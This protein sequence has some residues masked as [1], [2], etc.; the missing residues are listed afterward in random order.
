[1]NSLTDFNETL[2]EI[3]AEMTTTTTKPPQN[4]TPP[5]TTPNKPLPPV[6]TSSLSP[7]RKHKT[8]EAPQKG[9]DDSVNN[10]L[11]EA[12][13]QEDIQG[14]S[15]DEEE[16]TMSQNIV[17]PA[18]VSPGILR[19]DDSGSKVGGA[20]KRTV[21]FQDDQRQRVDPSYE[22]RIDKET[23][24]PLSVAEAKLKLFGQQE[25]KVA[26]YRR[27]NN[28]EEDKTLQAE[29][30]NVTPHQKEEEPCIV[31]PPTTV[32]EEDQPKD[33]LVQFIESA[34][35]STS[36]ME[37]PPP[38]NDGGVATKKGFFTMVGEDEAPPTTTTFNQP[39]H[40]MLSSQGEEGTEG[41]ESPL[42][43]STSS[44]PHPPING[45]PVWATTTTTATGGSFNSNNN[46]QNPVYR[47]LV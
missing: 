19:K 4:L 2:N 41:N 13:Q 18:P 30:S 43:D 47:S 45:Q 10:Y 23:N 16:E 7:G 29:L 25:T 31:A 35:E 15:T 37:T 1:M 33:D 27:S 3:A 11:D 24:R 34:L 38:S 26:R 6:R 9:E 5:Q 14:I 21:I 8:I 32:S 39:T 42:E 46:S 28:L 40:Y 12:F 17:K 22:P 20:N 36:Y 44:E